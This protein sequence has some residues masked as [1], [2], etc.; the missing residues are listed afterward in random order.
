MRSTASVTLACLLMCGCG[1]FEGPQD[2]AIERLR[3]HRPPPSEVLDDIEAR[4]A[5]HECVADVSH[6]E[7]HYYWG[8]LQGPYADETKIFF[9]FIKPTAHPMRPGRHISLPG[10][11]AV[12]DAPGTVALGWLNRT[13]GKLILEECGDNYGDRHFSPVE[14]P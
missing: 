1:A 11:P 10:G 3:A 4:L 14:I 6:W 13:T 9:V 12:G 8:L 5:T 2:T 7:R